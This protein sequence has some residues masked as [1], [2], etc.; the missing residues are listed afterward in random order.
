ATTKITPFYAN[1]GYEPSTNWPTEV[2]F[3]NPA[4]E[5]YAHYMVEVYRN[6]ESQLEMTGKKMGEY[7]DRKRKPA[8]LSRLCR[9]RIEEGIRI[10]EGEREYEGKQVLLEGIRFCW[11]ESGF[12]GKDQVLLEGIRFCW[13]RCKYGVMDMA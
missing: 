9:V 10:D 12:V 2:Q 13:L 6:L 3:Q 1:Y 4:S 11:K 8:P 5:L 7:Y